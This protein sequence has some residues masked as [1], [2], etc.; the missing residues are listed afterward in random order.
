MINIDMFTKKNEQINVIEIKYKYE[1]RDGYFGVNTG[2]MKM[3]EFF[4]RL[5]FNVHHF[6]LYNFTRDMNLSIFG[7]LRLN[8]EPPNEKEWYFKKLNVEEVYNE[9][10][11]PEMTSVSGKFRQSYFKIPKREIERNRMT[12]V[13]TYMQGE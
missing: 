3:F 2:Q 9:S 11:A 12:F 1:S 4:M 7:F 6:V 8:S 10:I 13:S 5:N